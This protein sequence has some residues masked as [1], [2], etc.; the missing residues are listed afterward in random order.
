[1][2]TQG[3]SDHRGNK[4]SKHNLLDG[5]FGLWQKNRRKI[6]SEGVE[7]QNCHAVFEML[8]FLLFHVHYLEVTFVEKSR[9]LL[10]DHFKENFHPIYAN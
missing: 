5:V 1:V 7:L 6:S 3:V 2:F 10:A 4:I 9:K 8:L